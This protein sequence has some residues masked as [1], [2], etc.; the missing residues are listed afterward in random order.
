VRRCV[1]PEEA[2]PRAEWTRTKLTL[3]VACPGLARRRRACRFASSPPRKA[4]SPMVA[5]KVFGA[6]VS[7]GV[8]A[9]GGRRGRGGGRAGGDERAW[10]PTRTIT[11]T[12]TSVAPDG[13][14]RCRLLPA[15]VAIGA[16]A[17]DSRHPTVLSGERSLLSMIII[18]TRRET[19][20]EAV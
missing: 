13:T 8:L 3:S 12:S 20:D 10:L 9:G 16:D 19:A 18:F 17:D 2:K 14:G 11:D 15:H 5:R 7:C 6:V 1:A 4:P